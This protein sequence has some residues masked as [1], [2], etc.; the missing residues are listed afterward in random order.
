[1][2]KGRYDITERRIAAWK[3]QGRGEGHGA[4]YK[5][6]L[7][8][9]NV[10]STG[11]SSRLLGVT[12][13]RMHQLLSDIERG[14]CLA[15]D[16]CES[17]VDIREQFPLPREETIAIA[18]EMG[19][20]HPKQGGVDVVMTTDFLVDVRQGSEVRLEAIAVKSAS[21]LDDKRTIEKL[22][23]ERRYWLRRGV[24]WRIS[25]ELDLTFGEKMLALWC[26][27]MDSFEHFEAPSV[28]SWAEQCDRLVAELERSNAQ[29]LSA[30]FKR[31]ET[32]H[33]F[34][35]GDALTVIRH[36]LQVGRLKLSGKSGF[37]PRGLTSQLVI[38]PR[39]ADAAGSA[40]VQAA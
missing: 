2:A 13:K 24:A 17:V 1:M 19:V 9:Q 31:L 28:G 6:W 39:A 11:R 3:K 21:A 38:Q 36:L 40:G 26:H 20:K 15:L 16:G 10:P 29:P 22:E 34:E 14:V 32:E 4:E 23:I 30:F 25:T 12:T 7:T 33:G 37:A 35:P 27:G 5:P 8:I 18:A